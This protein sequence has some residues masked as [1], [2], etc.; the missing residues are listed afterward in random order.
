MTMPS[1]TS[2]Q[3]RIA[4]TARR[5]SRLGTLPSNAKSDATGT[6]ISI[7]VD[8]ESILAA[9]TDYDTVEHV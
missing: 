5:I 6:S 4:S 9:H 2:Q 8:L 1:L 3:C 7:P